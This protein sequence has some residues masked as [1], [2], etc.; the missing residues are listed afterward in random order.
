MSFSIDLGKL[1]SNLKNLLLKLNEV[2]YSHI[3]SFLINYKDEI[4][5]SA[6]L[7]SLFTTYKLLKF[8]NKNID[9]V[10]NLSPGRIYTLEGKV[11]I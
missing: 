6:L 3:I 1:F 7:I 9:K 5:V 11:R 2:K 4:S 10:A 8:G